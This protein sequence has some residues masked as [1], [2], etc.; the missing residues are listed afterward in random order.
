MF[1]PTPSQLPPKRIDQPPKADHRREITAWKALVWAY[2]DEL[3]L[4]ASAPGP[5]SF[6]SE[7]PQMSGLGRER[8]GGGAINGWYEPHAD[9]RLIH[10]KLEAWFNHDR[11]GCQAIMWH[12]ERRR[13]IAPAI[14]VPRLRAV[15]VLDRQGEVLIERIRS[16]RKARV[17]AQYCLVEF[18]GTDPAVAASKERAWKDLYRLFVAFLDV[19]PGFPLTKWR[20]AE[21]GLTNVGESLTT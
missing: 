21:R 11:Q 10:A 1:L 9:A 4:A 16:D 19:M 15:A 12:A 7:G 13:E 6:V 17:S 14:S 5:A 3:V 8:I 20:I 18:E 2:A